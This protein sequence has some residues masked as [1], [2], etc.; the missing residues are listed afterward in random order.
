[1]L[2]RKGRQCAEY[3]KGINNMKRKIKSYLVFTSLIYRIVIFLL[4]PLGAIGVYALMSD[5]SWGVRLV[6]IMELLIMAEI[7][8]DSWLFGGIQ[9]KAAERLDYLKTSARGGRILKT[10]LKLDLVRRVLTAAVI[11]GIC[12]LMAGVFANGV[13]IWVNYIYTILVTYTI[14]MLGVFITRFE[15]GI[16][17]NMVVSY[18]AGI[19]AL[20]IWFLPGLTEHVGIYVCVFALL[21]V[22]VSVLA[23]KVAFKKVEG[24]YY[25]K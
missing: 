25:D 23:L 13:H 4:L 20:V 21:A 22:G 16:W 2:P 9:S 5:F 10:A 8:L 3:W 12:Y 19:V 6:V 11:Y 1:M 17:V 18:V 15:S 7:F 14:S 24:S